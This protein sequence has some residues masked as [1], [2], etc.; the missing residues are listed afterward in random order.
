MGARRTNKQPI[1]PAPR[2]EQ[3]C[4]RAALAWCSN[5][6]LCSSGRKTRDS[7]ADASS[8]ALGCNLISVPI[9]IKLMRAQKLMNISAVFEEA[10]QFNP[11]FMVAFPLS[12]HTLFC[13]CVLTQEI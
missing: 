10:A 5:N 2:T 3:Y 1:I 12:E 7:I 8:K 6:S 4:T 9:K 13:S 11:C